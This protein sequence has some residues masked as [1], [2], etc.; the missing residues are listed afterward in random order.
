MFPIKSLARKRV[1]ATKTES[2]QQGSWLVISGIGTLVIR[3]S[4]SSLL[5]IATAIK[6]ESK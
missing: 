2:E 3:T 1:N 5:G 6:S 4:A